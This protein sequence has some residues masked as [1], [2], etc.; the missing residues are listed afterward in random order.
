MEPEFWIKRWQTGDIGFHRDEV[1]PALQEFWPHVAATHE[2]E[3]FVPLCGKSLDMKWL[4]ARGHNVVGVELSELAV[5]A[6]FANEGL[7]PHVRSEGA[8][9]VKSA[10]RY[11]LWCGDLFELPK[12]AVPGIATFYDRASLIALP[13]HMRSRYAQRLE[14][15]MTAGARGLLISL[16]Y[17]QSEMDGPPFSVTG[18]E[19]ALLFKDGFSI[20]VLSRREALAAN[21]NLAKRGLTGLFET[22]YLLRRCP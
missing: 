12:D 8:F 21:P 1:H 7:S 22:C 2:E 11:E 3:V 20:E 4:A 13:P 5:D 14:E 15:M 19:I 10:G 6:F 18:E 9:T 17:D 16:E